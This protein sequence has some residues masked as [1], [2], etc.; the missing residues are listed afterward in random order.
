[1]FKV[2]SK[3]CQQIAK[4]K[5]TFFFLKIMN[6]IHYKESLMRSGTDVASFEL[7]IL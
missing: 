2:G 4:M 5:N 7:C 3:I 6:S 1:M